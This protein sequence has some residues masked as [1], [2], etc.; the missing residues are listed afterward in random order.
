MMW[1][2]R[3]RKLVEAHW[4]LSL[5]AVQYNLIGFLESY[6]ILWKILEKCNNVIQDTFKIHK[7]Y[8][9]MRK[10]GNEQ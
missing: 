7:G 10:N 4:Y 6:S 8:K 2:R 1:V 9:E 5:D 3:K